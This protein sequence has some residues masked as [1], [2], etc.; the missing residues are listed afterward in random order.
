MRAAFLLFVVLAGCASAPPPARCFV[1]DEGVAREI[2]AAV[3]G[4]SAG[5]TA[6]M[7]SDAGDHWR[8]SRSPDAH[9]EGDQIVTADNGLSFE[10][11]KCSGAMSDYRQW[12]R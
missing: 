11:D 6:I 3:L 8:V 12:H 5:D 7:L 10:I 2:A 4:V 9:L 1:Q